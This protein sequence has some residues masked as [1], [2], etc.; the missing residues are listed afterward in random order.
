[1]TNLQIIKEFSNQIRTLYTLKNLAYKYDNT[2]LVLT[3]AEWE[4]IKLNHIDKRDWLRNGM[5]SDEWYNE[6][7]ESSRKILNTVI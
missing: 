1:M 5:T 2:N 7:I 4:T 6:M 3:E